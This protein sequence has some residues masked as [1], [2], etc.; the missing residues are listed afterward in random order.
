MR[1][2]GLLEDGR[3]PANLGVPDVHEELERF[4]RLFEYLESVVPKDAQKAMQFFLGKE[5]RSGDKQDARSGGDIE[6]ESRWE[7]KLQLAED[8][9]RRDVGNTMHAVKNMQREALGNSDR[10]DKLE[11][12]IPGLIGNVEGLRRQANMQSFPNF[13]FE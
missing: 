11:R 1:L 6:N 7:T 5:W 12:L 4:R 3:S 10:L 2:T 9:M 8:S 13:V